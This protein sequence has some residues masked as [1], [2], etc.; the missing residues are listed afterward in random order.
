MRNI[1]NLQ[2]WNQSTITYHEMTIDAM[3][4]KIIFVQCKWKTR[5][6]IRK[7]KASHLNQR[8][9]CWLISHIFRQRKI[10]NLAK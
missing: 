9:V 7:H 2:S 5:T 8:V 6:R 4:Y 3:H 10:V 1:P